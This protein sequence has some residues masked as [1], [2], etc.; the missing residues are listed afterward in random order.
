[1]STRIYVGGINDTITREHLEDLFGK[2][3]KTEHV[4]VAFNPPGFAFVNFE[5]EQSATDAVDA[6][7]G[8]E[9]MGC[10][11]RVEVSRPRAP[12]GRGGRGGSREGCELPSYT[13]FFLCSVL[14][15]SDEH[16]LK[17]QL[18]SLGSLFVFNCKSHRGWRRIWRRPRWWWWPWRWRWLR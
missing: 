14:H 7:N 15:C 12:G 1:M 5:T 6:L 8:E 10:K 13:L 3:G 17:T 16:H 4:W 11:L 18:N 9:F 2:Y